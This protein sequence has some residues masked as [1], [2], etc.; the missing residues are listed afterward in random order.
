MI[1]KKADFA[2]RFEAK[3][4]SRSREREKFLDK[5]A[6]NLNK[7]AESL[8]VTIYC[9]FQKN[10]LEIESFCITREITELDALLEVMPV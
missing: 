2:F 9:T 5:I 8:Y 10:V 6:F 3:K 4:I 7:P 1:V